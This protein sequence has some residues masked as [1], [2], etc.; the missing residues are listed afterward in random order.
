M[1]NKK[2]ILYTSVKRNKLLFTCVLVFIF[3]ILIAV[4][5]PYI[6]PY[7]PTHIDILNRL[8]PPNSNNLFGTD[9]YGR[10]ILSRMIYGSRTSLLA[11]ILTMLSAM[12]FGSII[13]L[14]SGYFRGIFDSIVMRLM[15]TLMAF[16]AILLA[17]ALMAV[18]G[19]GL[20]NVII[21]LSIVYTPRLSRIIRSLVLSIRE[22]QFVESAQSLGASI[23]RILFHHI[24]PQCIGIL[25]VQGSFIF[26]YAVIAEA[27][28]SFLGIGTPPPGASWGN[29]LSEGRNYLSFAPWITIFPGL[30]IMSI[31]LLLN[32]MGDTLR[33]TLDPRLKKLL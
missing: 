29:I 16:P 25:F 17:I 8:Q 15:D 12:I 5:A 18:L 24:F 14:V 20:R 31:V 22:E 28:L 21:S 2:Q 4:F 7:H 26:A 19:S 10:D 23:P 32:L 11:G 13:G 3:F 30:A 9:S 6:A 27:G 33:D 1:N